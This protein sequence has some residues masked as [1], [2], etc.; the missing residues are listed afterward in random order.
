[1]LLLAVAGKERLIYLSVEIGLTGTRLF[2]FL[3]VCLL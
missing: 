2:V 3:S 1:M